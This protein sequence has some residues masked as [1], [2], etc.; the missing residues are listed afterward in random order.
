MLILMNNIRSG[1]CK[2]SFGGD[3]ALVAVF[4]SIVGTRGRPRHQGVMVVMG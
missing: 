3:D 4:A 1:M 2:V